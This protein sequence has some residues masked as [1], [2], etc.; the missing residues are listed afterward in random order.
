MSPG[1]TVFSGSRPAAG[2]RKSKANDTHEDTANSFGVVYANNLA[3]GAVVS[4]PPTMFP[5]GSIIVRER[6]AHADDPQPQHLV[7]MIKRQAGFNPAA[8]DWEFLAIDGAMTKIE[9]R[10]KKGGCLDCHASQ[11]DRDFV[12]PSMTQ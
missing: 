10:Q 3:Q 8:N 6:L 2:S 5:R 1:L 4:N 9:Q 7:V 11:K 12:Y